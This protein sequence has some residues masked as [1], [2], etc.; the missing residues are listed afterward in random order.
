MHWHCRSGP[1]DEALLASLVLLAKNQVLLPPPPLIQLAEPTVAI[2]LRVFLSV[3]F[4]S[5]LQCQMGMLLELIVEGWKIRKG[6]LEGLFF[7][8]LSKY[9]FFNP[10]LVPSGNGHCIPAAAAFFR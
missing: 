7:R 4:P 10:L 1:I 2:S 9:D 6:T 8:R 5:Q 3:L